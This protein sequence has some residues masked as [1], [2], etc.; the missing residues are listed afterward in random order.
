GSSEIMPQGVLCRWLPLDRGVHVDF[1]GLYQL[2]SQWHRLDI[3]YDASASDS[4]SEPWR[5]GSY[6]F[7]ALLHEIGH[8]LGLTHPFDGDD[9]LPSS[10]DNRLYTV[11]SYTEVSNN[12]YTYFNESGSYWSDPARTLVSIPATMSTASSLIV[13]L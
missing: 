9:R 1:P 10:V 4:Y 3:A 7:L 6:N 12:P 2:A 5:E 11:M 8:A 13:L